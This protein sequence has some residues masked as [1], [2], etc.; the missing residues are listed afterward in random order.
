MPA[1]PCK[2]RVTGPDGILL[3]HVDIEADE[4]V[5]R[6]EAC[7]GVEG[8]EGGMLQGRGAAPAVRDWMLGRSPPANREWNRPRRWLSDSG[9]SQSALPVTWLSSPASSG[10]TGLRCC[11]RHFA[12]CTAQG[13][14]FP[15]RTNNWHY[16]RRASRSAEFRFIS[17]ASKEGW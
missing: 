13:A 15:P 16:T 7:T 2:R 10:L 4:A 5:P 6:G 3:R 9:P 17:L 1:A 12:A 14:G 11:L 8:C